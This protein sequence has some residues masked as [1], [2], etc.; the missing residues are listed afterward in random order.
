MI[1]VGEIAGYFNHINQNSHLFPGTHFEA[2][3]GPKNVKLRK[4]SKIYR[5]PNFNNLYFRFLFAITTS[6]RKIIQIT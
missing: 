6:T 1:Y 4:T 5:K 3:F 2:L